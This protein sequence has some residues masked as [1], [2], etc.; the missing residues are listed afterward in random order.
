M[1]INF[2]VPEIVRSGGIRVIFEFAN[3]L[4]DLGNDITMYTPVIPFN[5][6]S[7]EIKKH[8]FSHQVKYALRQLSGRA[9]MPAD[10]F[11]Y[12]F[13]IKAVPGVNNVTIRNADAVFA[14]AWTTAHPVNSLSAKKGKKFY[15]IQDYEKWN[16]NIKR[17][18]ESYTLPLNRIVIAE[19]LRIFLKEKFGSESKVIRYGLNFEKFNNPGKKFSRP[20][21]LLYMDHQLPNK[22]AKAAIE[23]IK[24]IKNKYPDVKVKGFGMNIYNGIPEYIKFT[25]NPDD[26]KLRELYSTSDIYIYPTLFEGCPTTPLEAMACKCAVTANAAAEIPYYITHKESGMLADPLKPEQL[27]EGVCFLIENP[28]ELKRISLNGFES[29]QKM[30]RWDDKVKELV[31]FINSAK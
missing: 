5:A 7:P 27:F 22:N 31:E 26:N 2:I 24:L 28:E 10:I 4:T 12:K 8:V 19:H 6:Y 9:K 14:T 20:I 11:N 30:F 15:F 23:T 16:A 1:K 17:V 18:D 25:K 3:R 13:R 29:V 21:T